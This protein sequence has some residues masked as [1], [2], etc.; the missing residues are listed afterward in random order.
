[1][2]ILLCVHFIC[3]Q[4]DPCYTVNLIR[5]NAG[6]DID[7]LMSHESILLWRVHVTAWNSLILRMELKPVIQV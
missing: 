2:R 5:S 4:V 1:M 3:E 6:L 7:L